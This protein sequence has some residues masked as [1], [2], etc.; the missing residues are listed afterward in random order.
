MKIIKKF[1]LLI[2]VVFALSAGAFTRAAEPDNRPEVVTDLEEL[3]KAINAASDGDTIYLSG[4]INISGSVEIGSLD[5]SIFLYGIP[6]SPVVISVSDSMPDGECAFFRNLTFLGDSST[7]IVLEQHGGTSYFD[8]VFFRN[9]SA[10]TEQS[11][12]TISSGLATFRNC[13]FEESRGI[14]GSHIYAEASSSVVINDCQFFTGLASQNGGSIYSL[15]DLTIRNSLF[16]NSYAEECGGSIYASGPLQIVSSEFSG[17]YAR[18]GGHIYCSTSDSAQISGCTMSGSQVEQCGGSLYADG[19]LILSDCR[20]S[21]NIAGQSGGGIWSKQGLEVSFSKVF[22]NTAGVSGADIC[23]GPGLLISDSSQDYLSLYEQE[24]LDGG[25]NSAA[26]HLDQEWLRYSADATTAE[27]VTPNTVT[28]DFIQIVFALSYKAP[29]EQEP[30]MPNPQ[31]P[32]GDHEDDDELPDKDPPDEELPDEDPPGEGITPPPESEGSPPPS[33]DV[34]DD[35]MNNSWSSAPQRPSNVGQTHPSDSATDGAPSIVLRCGLA[36]IDLDH[37]EEFCNILPKY[38]PADKIIT[39]EEVAGF[40]YGLA[41]KPALNLQRE[42]FS[43]IK[44]SPFREA[45]DF[46]ASSG[47]VFGC[48]GGQFNPSSPLTQAQLL[49]IL[50]RFTEPVNISLTNIDV[51]GHWAETSVKTAVAS[52]WIEDSPIDLQAPVTFGGFIEILGAIIQ[53]SK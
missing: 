30:E 43:D 27:F 48:G 41:G 38:I 4:D 46:L 14:N 17:G 34:D 40:M 16:A 32:A 42:P 15:G 8:N 50:A 29:P 11:V 24:L 53:V 51:S 37:L 33:V 25:W 49:T 6:G 52:G 9:T 10:F 39:R 2:L 13:T 5:K 21:N 45:I 12:F 47:V 19:N 44:N 22:H 26:W 18:N 3:T 20:I 36:E 1:T 31:P 7:G 35:S 23:A 28:K